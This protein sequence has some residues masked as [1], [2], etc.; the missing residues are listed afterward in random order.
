VAKSA[1]KTPKQAKKAAKS[2]GKKPPAAPRSSAKAAKTAKTAKAPKSVK[3]TKSAKAAKPR[4]AGKATKA[5]KPKPASKKPATSKAPAGKASKSAKK[6]APARP[7]PKSAAASTRK[8]T[9]KGAK[10]A[11]AKP[12]K[13]AS[14]KARPT[15]PAGASSA[16]KAAPPV[17]VKMPT[18]GNSAGRTAKPSPITPS[19]LSFLAGKPGSDHASEV[20]D[21]ERPRLTKTK[22][23]ARDLTKFRDLLLAKKRQ[24]LGDV[25][26]MEKEALQG[27]GTN[28]SH[29]PVHLAD[30]GTDNYEQEFTLTLVD[31]DRRLL[32]EIDHAL[33]KLDGDTYG[34]CEGTGQMITKARL[35][36]EPWTRYSIEYA[37]D[38]KRHGVR[39]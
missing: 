6:T 39:R 3:S 2:P 4:P 8:P 37:R 23:N 25:Q 34:I 12:V 16:R 29:L 19:G 26:G 5:A 20:R 21:V 24:L 14:K 32:E 11:A 17:D 10:A 15:K 18:A 38:R 27:E 36:A 28:L 31:R 35:E 13:A 33:G 9:A 7:T 30:M 1:K 22:L